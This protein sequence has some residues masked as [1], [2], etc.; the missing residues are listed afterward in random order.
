MNH[1][2]SRITN[3][4]DVVNWCKQNLSH[5]F[6]ER[7]AN[8]RRYVIVS[9][10]INVFKCSYLICLNVHEYFYLNYEKK[11]YFYLNEKFDL[12][13][14]CVYLEHVLLEYCNGRC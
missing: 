13:K 8:V 12:H 1:S 11:V 7:M 4:N 14:L 6:N 3:L 9:M 2:A 5:E 10:T